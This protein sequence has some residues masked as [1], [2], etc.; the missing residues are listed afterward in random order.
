GRS[1]RDAIMKSRPRLFRTLKLSLLVTLAMSWTQ[2][3]GPVPAAADSHSEEAR[4]IDD[5]QAVAVAIPGDV[6]LSRGS[7][8]ALVIEA[9]AETL[10]RIVTEVQDGELRIYR[11]EGGRWSQLKGPIRVQ[12]TY[13]SLDALTLSGSADLKSD[14]I[15]AEDFQVKISGSASVA[16]S[17]LEAQSLAVTISGS[18]ELAVAELSADEAEIAVSGSG[19]VALTGEVTTQTVTVRG[20]GD[21]DNLSLASREAEARVS[22]SGNVRLSVSESLLARISGSG[23]IRYQGDPEVDSD[24]SGSGTLRKL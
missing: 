2:L 15:A 5:F 11:Q 24:V 9:P 12:I 6:I 8:P 7:A 16:L 17:G 18:G 1:M 22:G 23:D 3:L 13:E 19:D 4:D 10:E 21:V 14:V 20:S